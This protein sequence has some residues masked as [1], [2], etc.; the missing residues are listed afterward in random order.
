ML[1]G[2][3]AHVLI[4][5]ALN[6]PL[7]LTLIDSYLH[8]LRLLRLLIEIPERRLRAARGADFGWRADALRSSQNPASDDA[9]RG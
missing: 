2:I 4:E 3:E 9:P 6:S 7:I 8:T 1:P 5:V